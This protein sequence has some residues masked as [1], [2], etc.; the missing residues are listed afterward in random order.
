MRTG[1]RKKISVWEKCGDLNA[2]KDVGSRAL[3]IPKSWH[4]RDDSGWG[5]D[6]GCVEKPPCDISEGTG[7]LCP[8]CASAAA[9]KRILEMAQRCSKVVR[10]VALPLS[11][12]EDEALGRLQCTAII[13]C[14]G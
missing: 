13:I 5:H 12:Q 2:Q 7:D 1:V 10:G 3:A 11:V 4:W 6:G 14:A 8:G 9:V